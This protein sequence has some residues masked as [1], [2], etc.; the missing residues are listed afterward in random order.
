MTL[1][2]DTAVSGDAVATH[3]AGGK[4]HQVFIPAHASGHI[5]GTIPTYTFWRPFAAGAQNQRTL[6]L[7]NAAGSGVIVKCRKLFVHHNGATVT[8]VAHLFDVIHTTAVGTGGTAITGRKQDSTSADIPSQVTARL[9]A[10]GG[11]TESFVRF[12]FSVDTEETRPGTQYAPSIN[13]LPEGDDIGDVVL[14]EGEGILIKQ[15]TNSTVGV[16]GC[17]LVVTIE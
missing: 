6:D 4:E 17:F 1:A 3:L 15:I 8:G 14:R 2:S 5:R 16:W 13:W 10:T 11:A 7:F 12:G 9:S